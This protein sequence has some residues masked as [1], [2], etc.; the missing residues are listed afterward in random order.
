MLHWKISWPNQQLAKEG[1]GIHLSILDTIAPRVG[2]KKLRF[3]VGF[4][5]KTIFYVGVP[6]YVLFVVFTLFIFDKEIELPS[7]TATR[8]ESEALAVV[9]EY[10]KTTDVRT[11]DDFDVSTNCWAEF[12]DKEFTVEYLEITGT[13]RVN[14][15]YRQVRYYWRVNDATMELTRDL[16]FQPRARMIRC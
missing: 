11:I 13:W 7:I 12:G 8:T 16:W 2:R 9:H 14:A 6:S 10:L 15:Y 1:S 5:F 4:F 3:G